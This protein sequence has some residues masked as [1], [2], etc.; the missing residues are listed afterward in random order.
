MICGIDLFKRELEEGGAMGG[1]EIYVGVYFF[2]GFGPG[3]GTGSLN[4]YR[5]SCMHR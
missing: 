4:C 1:R 5:K 2:S 3:F